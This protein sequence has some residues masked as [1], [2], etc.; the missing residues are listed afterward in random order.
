MRTKYKPWAK[1]YLE[2]HLEVQ[3]EEEK[4]KTLQDIYLEIGS[5]KGGFL[6]NQAIKYPERFYLGVERNVTCCGF[7]A[8][9]LVE[10]KIENAKLLF[11]DGEKVLDELKD[12]SVDVLFLNFS[13][14]WPK[15]RHEKRRLTYPGLVAKYYRVLKR[16]GE[17]RFKTDN[18]ELFNFSKESFLTSPFKVKSI[19]DDYDGLDETDS[20]TEYEIKKRKA[21][22]AIHRLILTKE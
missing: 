9:S 18:E 11:I 13:D 15:K 16:G 10:S 4:V 8:K 14:P 22:F 6:I 21:G 19:T 2:E 12:E 7:I 1:P 5:G 17:L 20:K 3:L